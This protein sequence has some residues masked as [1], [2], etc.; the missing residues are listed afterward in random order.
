MEVENWGA[1]ITEK[2]IAEFSVGLE[3]GV[4]SI[5]L[6]PASE[7]FIATKLTAG[8]MG[9][10]EEMTE[11]HVECFLPYEFGGL[12]TCD[13]AVMVWDSVVATSVAITCTDE[14]GDLTNTYHNL[15]Q[16]VRPSD[17]G[18]FKPATPNDLGFLAGM[19]I[20]ALYYE[21]DQN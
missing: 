5:D 10:N 13:V 2:E 3:E 14:K 4:R 15:N 20:A 8:Q 1:T 9:W 18:P 19:A 7:Q 21:I 6:S 16:A 12:D 11:M 17:G